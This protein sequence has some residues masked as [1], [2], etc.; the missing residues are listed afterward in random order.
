[1]QNQRRKQLRQINC[2]VANIFLL[3]LLSKSS[4][5]LLLV[6]EA[7]STVFLYV[8]QMR[9]NMTDNNNNNRYEWSDVETEVFLDLIWRT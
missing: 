9:E 6:Q 2:D 7:E 1:M 5:R 3:V 4:K 8:P